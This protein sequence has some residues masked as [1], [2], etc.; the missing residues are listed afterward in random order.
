MFFMRNIPKTKKV[1][2]EDIKRM[3]IVGKCVPK[4]SSDKDKGA[5]FLM[6]RAPLM[7]SGIRTNRRVSH[8]VAYASNEVP[9][10]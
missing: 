3:H 7:S 1:G 5:S 6:T 4:E 8:E 10:L 2:N 9:A